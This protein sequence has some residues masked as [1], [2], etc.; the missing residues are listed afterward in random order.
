M[1]WGC[2]E[3]S[4]S[5]LEVEGNVPISTQCPKYDQVEELV[6]YQGDESEAAHVGERARASE[7]TVQSR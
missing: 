7:Q 4:K 6:D 1:V 5:L 2:R 3:M